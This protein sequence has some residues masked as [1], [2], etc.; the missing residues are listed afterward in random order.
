MLSS[1]PLFRKCGGADCFPVPDI[2]ERWFIQSPDIDLPPFSLL[3]LDETD[4]MQSMP[5][6]CSSADDPDSCREE[7]DDEIISSAP[8]SD[9]ELE[10]DKLSASTGRC[11]EDQYQRFCRLIAAAKEIARKAATSEE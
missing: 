7:D 5:S 11:S 4:E 1:D 8:A 9:D 6:K 10:A 2:T 3:M